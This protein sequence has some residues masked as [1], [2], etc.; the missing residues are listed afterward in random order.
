MTYQP[1]PLP[2]WL[3]QV[4]ADVQRQPAWQAFVDALLARVR[5]A[6]DR[7]H[8]TQFS[9]LAPKEQQVLMADVFFELSPSA[10]FAAFQKVPAHARLI[11]EPDHGCVLT[12]P[13]VSVRGC[14]VW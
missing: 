9:D 10:E 13:L 2:A 8:V 11:G 1:K 5:L 4:R 3:A 7:N 6:L 14:A 12:P